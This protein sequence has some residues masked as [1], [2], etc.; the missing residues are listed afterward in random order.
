[1]KCNA[2]NSLL[3]TDI[4]GSVLPFI[5][6]NT[7]DGVTT[8]LTPK[9]DESCSPEIELPNLLPF[10]KDGHFKAYVCIIQI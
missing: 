9:Y 3:H 5:S 7:T 1:M 6:L 10:G 8:L 4:L 2:I